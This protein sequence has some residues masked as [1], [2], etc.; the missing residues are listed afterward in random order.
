VAAS[1]P[2]NPLRDRDLLGAAARK[3]AADVLS[4]RR[5]MT[6]M[7]FCV[8]V[9]RSLELSEI[10]VGQSERIYISGVR[11]ATLG[12]DDASIIVKPGPAEPVSLP[13]F[14]QILQSLEGRER[15]D[16]APEALAQFLRPHCSELRARSLVHIKG[17]L[18][19]RVADIAR[20]LAHGAASD[21]RA[22]ALRE[23]SGTG[24]GGAYSEV[25]LSK[26]PLL[27]ALRDTLA[28]ELKELL[29]WH[30]QPEGTRDTV[31]EKVVATRYAAGGV[32]WAHQDQSG[33]GYQAYLL[34]SRPGVDFRAGQLYITDPAARAAGAPEGDATRQVEW[35][36]AGDLVVFAANAKEVPSVGRPRNWL[37]GFREVAPG[38]AG[39]DACH[40]CVV[41]LLE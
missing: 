33:G 17:L 39:A 4:T 31:G 20:A 38:S 3:L 37:H 1:P 9:L 16:A 5:T 21:E 29:T 13:G 24:R 35:H 2:H 12:S 6:A 15:S 36:S 14:R 23:S 32:N 27:R 22:T 18:S 34:L 7:A 28:A 30:E 41:G 26:A 11:K 10:A 19:D 25:A 8:E 40:L